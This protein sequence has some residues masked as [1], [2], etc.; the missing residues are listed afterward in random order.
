M[1]S[2][3]S[4]IWTTLMSKQTGRQRDTGL[5]GLT[6]AQVE[7]RYRQASGVDKL[8][9]QRELKARQQRNK[10][11]SRGGGREPKKTPQDPSG[12]ENKMELFGSF[13]FGDVETDELTSA[14]GDFGRFD[15]FARESLSM[16]LLFNSMKTLDSFWQLYDAWDPKKN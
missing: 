6:D 1:T 5:V 12:G 9:Y 16:E 7:E 2:I 13:N 8:R 3:G 4:A 14:P 10:G 15:V 11:K